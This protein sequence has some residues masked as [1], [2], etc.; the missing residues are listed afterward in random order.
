MRGRAAAVED[1]SFKRALEVMADLYASA[2]GTTVL[3]FKEVP[4]RPKKYDGALALFDLA[5][6]A[7]EEIIR[8]AFSRFGTIVSVTVGGWPPAILRFSTHEAALAA[9]KA[10]PPVAVCGGL[11]D[12]ITA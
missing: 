11:L 3:Q 4:P 2:I 12:G 10:G 1:A 5:A 9:L 7:N 6:G 8:S